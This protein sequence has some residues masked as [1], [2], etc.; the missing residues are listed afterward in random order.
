MTFRTSGCFLNLLA[1]VSILLILLNFKNFLKTSK[2]KCEI[3]SC[4]FVD[5]GYFILWSKFWNLPKNTPN[6]EISFK[7]PRY[8]LQYSEIWLFAKIF[9][10]SPT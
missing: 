6:F 2:F 5:I 9:K 10:K 4:V 1:Q 7:D 8:H 3:F